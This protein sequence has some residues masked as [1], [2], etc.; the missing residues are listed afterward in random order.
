ML[1]LAVTMRKNYFDVK[2]RKV[3]H[4]CNFIYQL[5]LRDSSH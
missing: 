3:K 5:Q 4:L 2:L 1:A